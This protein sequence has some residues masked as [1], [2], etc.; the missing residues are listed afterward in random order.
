MADRCFGSGCEKIRHQDHDGGGRDEEKV[1]K[2][3]SSVPKKWRL[4]GT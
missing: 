3:R 1:P 2:K 4:S